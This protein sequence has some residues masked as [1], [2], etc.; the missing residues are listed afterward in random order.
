MFPSLIPA[1]PSV[2]SIVRPAP[3][4]LTTSEKKLLFCLFFPKACHNPHDHKPPT[5]VPGPVPA[6]GLAAAFGWSRK[7]RK[8]IS[9]RQP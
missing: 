8:R 6:L 9:E 5:D 4:T 7:L 1:V 2:P 3:A